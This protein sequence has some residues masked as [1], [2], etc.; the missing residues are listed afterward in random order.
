VVVNRL[1]AAALVDEEVDAVGT[2]ELVGWMK[3]NAGIVVA[4]SE[5]ARGRLDDPKSVPWLA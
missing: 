1:K 4:T 5:L 2:P 3:A